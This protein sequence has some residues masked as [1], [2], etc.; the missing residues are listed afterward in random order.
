MRIFC[1]ICYMWLKNI[2]FEFMSDKI[3]EYGEDA[4]G[5]WGLFSKRKK[6]IK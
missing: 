3:F 1:I 4:G 6:I 2:R 5:I